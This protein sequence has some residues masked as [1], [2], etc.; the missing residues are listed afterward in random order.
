MPRV[1]PLG[2]DTPADALTICL[3]TYGE[4]WLEEVARL[5]GVDGQR[6]REQRGELVLDDPES[7]EHLIPAAAYPS[8][9]VRRKLETAR[10]AAEHDPRFEVNVAALLAIVPATSPRMTSR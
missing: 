3:D 1:R 5:L 10:A 8:D 4:V 6:A 7:P 2:A 9:N